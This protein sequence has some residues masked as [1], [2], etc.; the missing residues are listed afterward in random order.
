ML[1]HFYSYTP[2]AIPKALCDYIIKTTPWDKGFAAQLS[3]DNVDLFV[4]DGVRK[5]RS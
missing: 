4:D 1:K 2:K 3:D 5:T